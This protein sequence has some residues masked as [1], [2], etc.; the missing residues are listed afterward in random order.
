ME[1][2]NREWDKKTFRV[3]DHKYVWHVKV[4]HM[5]L[6]CAFG[7]AAVYMSTLVISAMLYLL[8]I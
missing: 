3:K 1:F 4:W 7:A 5:L 2:L 6:G 8:T